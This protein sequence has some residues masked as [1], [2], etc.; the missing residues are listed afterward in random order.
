V[1]L[2]HGCARDVLNN[3]LEGSFKV[4]CITGIYQYTTPTIFEVI[5]IVKIPKVSKYSIF[6]F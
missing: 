6:F 4:A 5:L 1:S 3:A 2:D